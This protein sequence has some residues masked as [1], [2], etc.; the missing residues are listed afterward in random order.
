MPSQAGLPGPGETSRRVR[1]LPVPEHAQRHA[2]HEPHPDVHAFPWSSN[3]RHMD[4]GTCPPPVDTSLMSHL[5]NV[6]NVA[7]AEEVMK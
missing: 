1:P 2:K 7:E 4:Q 6:A 5:Y 3:A